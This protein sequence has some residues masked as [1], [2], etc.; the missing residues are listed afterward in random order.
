MAKESLRPLIGGAVMLTGCVLITD[1]LLEAYYK[2]D[3]I[4]S[5]LLQKKPNKII[6]TGNRRIIISAC[7]SELCPRKKI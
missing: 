3:E 2:P 7:W 4:I 6:F 5:M 1:P